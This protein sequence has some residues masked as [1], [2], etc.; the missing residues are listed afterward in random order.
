MQVQRER[1]FLRGSFKVARYGFS[2]SIPPKCEHKLCRHE[3][4]FGKIATKVVLDK[5]KDLL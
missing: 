3:Q 4:R 5:D 2:G 1:K